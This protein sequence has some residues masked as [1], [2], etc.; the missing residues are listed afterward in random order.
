MANCNCGNVYNV[1]MGCCEPVLGPIENYYTKYQ[2]DKLISG[3]TVSGVTEE[4]MNEAISAATYGLASEEY[5]NNQ[6]SSQTADFVDGEEL[7]S[8]TYDKATIDSKIAS[9]G[10][11]DPTK[12]YNKTATD[13]LLAEKLDASAYTPT[14]LS[15]Y[16]TKNETSGATEIANALNLKQ[17][18]LT[19]GTGIDIT[20]NVI[21]A[22]GGGSSYTA[23]DGINI[24]NNVISTVTKFWCGTQAE[25]DLISPK[26]PNTLYLI[27]S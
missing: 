13:E 8:Y 27:H 25:Y 1:G 22:T 6:I 26:D 5:V 3:I 10:T 23:G 14:D 9:G 16:Y 17:D 19:A 21:S 2:V 18:I 7:S 15:N 20:N 4:E 11:F 24:T 12:Y